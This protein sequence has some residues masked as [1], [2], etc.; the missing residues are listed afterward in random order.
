M[1]VLRGRHAL[2]MEN[3]VALWN[4]TPPGSGVLLVPGMFL[5]ARAATAVSRLPQVS[6]AVMSRSSAFN[7]GGGA[8]MRQ[9][10]AGQTPIHIHLGSHRAGDQGDTKVW[11]ESPYTV[12]PGVP[13]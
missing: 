2:C 13:R 5:L 8:A 6:V 4:S 7:Q 11:P 12:T 3:W 10:D 9:T 1:P